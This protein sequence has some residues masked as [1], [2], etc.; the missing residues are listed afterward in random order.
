MDTPSHRLATRAAGTVQIVVYNL[1]DKGSAVTDADVRL[2]V[3]ASNLLMPKVAAAWGYIAPV[4]VFAGD[5]GGKAPN[6]GAW[7]FY[8]IGEDANVPDALAYHTEEGDVVD[9]YILTKTIL[10]N[11][12]VSLCDAKAPLKTE[13]VA[14]ALFHE[15]A[16]AFVDPTVNAWWQDANGVFYSAEVC[17]PVQG[18]N[19]LV[20]VTGSAS[21]PGGAPAVHQ[22]A[23]SDF[24]FPAWRDSQAPTDGS[25]QLNYTKTLKTPFT[26]DHGG[27]YVKFDPAVDAQPTQVFGRKVPAWV[28]ALKTKSWRVTKR[29]GWW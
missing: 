27:Y 7:K 4:V 22:V 25:V 12:G 21:H 23:L 8:M 10:S 16:E 26:L 13:T 28:R 18:N 19:V 5:L 14:S 24:I 11:G 15:L 29:N 9:G 6:A 3:A 17:D 1:L 2:M 20:E